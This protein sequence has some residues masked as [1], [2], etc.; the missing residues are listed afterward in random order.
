MSL[1]VDIH[2]H[3]ERRLAALL[4]L[5]PQSAQ[6]RIPPVVHD[7]LVPLFLFTVAVVAASYLLTSS[8][9]AAPPK[10]AAPAKRR[11]SKRRE[12]TVTCEEVAKHTSRDDVWVI[13]KDQDTGEHRVY[14][15]TDEVD[16][17]P[18]GDTILNNA[19]TDT[20]EGF[21]G[22]QHPGRVFDMIEDHFVAPLA[23]PEN[24]AKFKPA[25][26]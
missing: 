15:I 18:G 14:D 22:P 2:D 20:T 19:G 8:L 26:K 16:E 17:H 23:D 12:G 25:A 6:T 21:H 3:V 1:A 4:K 5:L 13:I 11:K 10:K 9:L 7:N 24:I